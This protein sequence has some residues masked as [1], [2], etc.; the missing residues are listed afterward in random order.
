[1]I[2]TSWFQLFPERRG[3]TYQDY[4]KFVD[5]RSQDTTPEL[6]VAGWW[7]NIQESKFNMKKT[8]ESCIFLP[9]CKRT[10][11]RRAC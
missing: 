2:D 6:V 8:E 1:V 11:G 4:I 9:W 5:P 7:V 3:R 10:V